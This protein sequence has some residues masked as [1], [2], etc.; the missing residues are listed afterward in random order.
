MVLFWDRAEVDGCMRDRRAGL[1]GHL[2]EGKLE[3]FS[4]VHPVDASKCGHVD[5]GDFW[6]FELWSS[7]RGLEIS[8]ASEAEVCKGGDVS[9]ELGTCKVVSNEILPNT[10]SINIL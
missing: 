6:C 10:Q 5:E 4:A 1:C 8:V 3:D 9:D 7:S 2:R